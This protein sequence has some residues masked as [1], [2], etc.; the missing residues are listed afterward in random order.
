ML[1]VTSSANGNPGCHQGADGRQYVAIAAGVRGHKRADRRRG[2]LHAF[3][4]RHRPHNGECELIVLGA[5][6]G[7]VWLMSGAA[8]RC[9]WWLP[10]SCANQCY[11][12]Q[13]C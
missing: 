4:R 1:W 7:G 3:K 10:R 2:L 6:V 12:S 8:C 5:A 13:F 9:C 11:S